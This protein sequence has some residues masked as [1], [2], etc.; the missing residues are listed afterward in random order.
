MGQQRFSPLNSWPDNASL[1][2]ARRLLWPV[3]QKYGRKISWA[4]LIELAGTLALEDM[5]FPILGFGAGRVDTWQSDEAIYW[6]SEETWFPEGNEA[7][8]NGSTDFYER[9]DKLEVPLP[10]THMGLIYVNPE[11]PDGNPDPKASALDTR[12]TF[13]RMGMNDSETVALIAGGHAFGKTHGAAVADDYVGAVPELAE[14]G[15]QQLG[16]ANSYKTGAG[17]DA[18]TSGIE[19]VWSTTPTQW[20][21]SFLHSLWTNKWTVVTGPG[22]AYQWEA[23]NGSLDYPDAFDN[24]TYHRPRMMTS[25]IG[26][27]ED[28]IYANI[29]MGYYKNFSKLTNDFAH[30]CK[31]PMSLSALHLLVCHEEVF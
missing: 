4:D 28:P 10:A 15:E 30:A 13:G 1:D 16:W 31:F 2:K 29:S 18:I 25:D 11:G 17:P 26:L 8:Y 27:R 19:V 6:G 7:R 21:N 20:S 14:M 9:A 3:K 12:V 22:G 23:L 5:G 24:T